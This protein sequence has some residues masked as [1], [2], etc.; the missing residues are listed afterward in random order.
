MQDSQILCASEC[1]QDMRRA[2]AADL[3]VVEVHI[4]AAKFQSIASAKMKPLS[5]LFATGHVQCGGKPAAGNPLT[6][7]GTGSENPRGVK[8]KSTATH[9]GD[10][11]GSPRLWPTVS[12]ATPN[13]TGHEQQSSRPECGIEGVIGWNFADA[14]AVDVDDSTIVDKIDSADN[15]EQGCVGFGS[16]ISGLIRADSGPSSSQEGTAR[17]NP[18]HSETQS[19]VVVGSSSGAWGPGNLVCLER[20]RE[21]RLHVMASGSQ[22]DCSNSD[23]DGGNSG[24]DVTEFD[25][26]AQ[27]TLDPVHKAQAPNNNDSFEAARTSIQVGVKGVDFADLL[28]AWERKELDGDDARTVA[29]A[30]MRGL[31]RS[32]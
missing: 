23:D 27:Q 21:Q 16:P 13:D 12:D 1:L 6:G 29:D 24:G 32:S 19:V 3:P 5:L 15:G 18:R 10:G 2:H 9:S 31:R 30:I 7:Q 17:Q 8:R 11:A 20:S 4:A 26:S 22:I 28:G 14:G 25:R